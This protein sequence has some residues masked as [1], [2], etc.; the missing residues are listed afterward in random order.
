MLLANESGGVG[1]CAL[2]LQRGRIIILDNEL[3]EGLIVNKSYV[4]AHT[5]NIVMRRPSAR[6]LAQEALGLQRII[7]PD[8]L[9]AQGI[10]SNVEMNQMSSMQRHLNQINLTLLELGLHDY[11]QVHRVAKTRIMASNRSDTNNTQQSHTS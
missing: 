2:Q 11:Q 9:S 1:Y 4:V 10:A 8:I 7:A 6:A 5:N 3:C